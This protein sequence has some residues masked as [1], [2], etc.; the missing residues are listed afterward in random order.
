MVASSAVFFKFPADGARLAVCELVT[1]DI[2]KIDSITLP[3]TH[4]LQATAAR[5][6]R[7]TAR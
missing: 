3:A 6:R 1:G 4:P 2:N 5:I 7:L